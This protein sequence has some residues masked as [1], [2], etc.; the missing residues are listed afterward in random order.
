MDIA[1][2][3]KKKDAK[4]ASGDDGAESERETGGNAPNRTRAELDREVG[5]SFGASD[6]CKVHDVLP[7]VC[8]CASRCYLCA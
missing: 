2:A 5:I 4:T 8:G 1:S 7:R 3:C 6:L